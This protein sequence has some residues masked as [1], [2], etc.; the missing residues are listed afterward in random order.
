MAMRWKFIPSQSHWTSLLILIDGGVTPLLLCPQ[1]M[2]IIVAPSMKLLPK[3]CQIKRSKDYEIPQQR[4]YLNFPESTRLLV[5]F[6][7]LQYGCREVEYCSV[8]FFLRPLLLWFRIIISSI[9]ISSSINR[10][11]ISRCRMRIIIRRIL[12]ILVIYT[13]F[14]IIFTIP[15]NVF[16]NFV[17]RYQPFL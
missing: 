1:Y 13:L 5:C 14:N 2:A 16:I 10:T 15:F 6:W 17:R 7:P 4:L 9:I 11:L 8:L 12:I 3:E